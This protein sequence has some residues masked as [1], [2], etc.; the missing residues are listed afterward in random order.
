MSQ[1]ASAVAEND[2]QRIK[3]IGEVDIGLVAKL[4]ATP[5]NQEGK[6]QSELEADLIKECSELLALKLHDWLQLTQK[7]RRPPAM[8]PHPN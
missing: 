5:K 2:R 3:W 1:C 6:K 8:L 7:S 4:L